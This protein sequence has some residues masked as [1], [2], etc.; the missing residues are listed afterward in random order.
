LLGSEQLIAAVKSG[1]FEAVTRLVE[2][3]GLD[4]MIAQGVSASAVFWTSQGDGKGTNE[5]LLIT[6]ATLLL[7]RRWA[8]AWRTARWHWSTSWSGM[9][10]V[11]YGKTLAARRS[12]FQKPPALID[13]NCGGCMDHQ[14]LA[15]L[16]AALK[17]DKFDILQYLLWRGADATSVN[18]SHMQGTPP[19]SV[20]CKHAIC[21]CLVS[22]RVG[23]PSSS[24]RSVRASSR[25]SR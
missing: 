8:S 14:S 5:L 10:S 3:E 15:T 2:E 19:H 17:A 22:S 11:W 21:C 6:L 20:P 4:P 13:S 24:G 12:P 9:D 1:D 23:H 18:V 25:L 7:R 16:S